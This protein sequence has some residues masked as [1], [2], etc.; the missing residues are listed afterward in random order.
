MVIDHLHRSW[1]DLAG[2]G[3]GLHPYAR[4]AGDHVEIGYVDASGT[5]RMLA[6]FPVPPEPERTVAAG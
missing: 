5:G 2:P 3:G 1:P 6:P 4:R